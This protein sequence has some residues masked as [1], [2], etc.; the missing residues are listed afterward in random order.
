MKPLIPALLLCLL[1]SPVRA[2]DCSQSVLDSIQQALGTPE[3]RADGET[4]NVVARTCKAWPYQPQQLLAAIAYDAGVEYQKTL[5]VAVLDQASGRLLSSYR[6]D[7]EEDALTE[8]GSNSLQLDTAR[9]QLAPQRRAFALRFFSSAR[10]PSCGEASWTDDLTLLLPDGPA[11]RP[12]LQLSMQR[13]M[14]EQGCLNA[15]V[16]HALWQSA[17]L[18]LAVENTSSQGLNDLRAS[19]SI[20][21]FAS[22]ADLGQ[23]KDHVEQVLLRFDGKSYQPQK[24]G[25][26]WMGD[27]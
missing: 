24:K 13:Q 11:L 25:L 19:A 23:R 8:V 10:G 1:A 18:S 2:D 22:E 7:I 6:Q 16:E 20:Q 3:L 12:L 9:Y 26:W 5:V 21:W 17:N 15:G 14:A 27:Y 4:P